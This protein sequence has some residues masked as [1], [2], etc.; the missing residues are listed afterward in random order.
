MNDKKI[1]ILIQQKPP[2]PQPFP[3]LQILVQ[4]RIRI[5]QNCAIL[6]VFGSA[7]GSAAEPDAILTGAG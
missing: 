2:D 1:L 7:C 3:I 4:S 6:T 5:Q